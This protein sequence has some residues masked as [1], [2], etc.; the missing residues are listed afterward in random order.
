MQAFSI[1]CKELKNF[2]DLLHKHAR[3][4]GSPLIEDKLFYLGFNKVV[5]GFLR[6]YLSEKSTVVS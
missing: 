2:A 4:I 3:C 6:K 5:S 1:V